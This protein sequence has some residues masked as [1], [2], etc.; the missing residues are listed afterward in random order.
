MVT[1]SELRQ[2]CKKEYWG[3]YNR[4]MH[5]VGFYLTKVF[6]N[7]PVTSNQITVVWLLMGIAGGIL[8]ATGI[9]KWMLLGIVIYHL[10]HFFDC[11]DGNLARYRNKSTVKGIYLEQISHHITI[12]IVLAGLSIGVFNMMQNWL[13]LYVGCILVFSFIFAKL[14]SSNLSY[15]KGESRD[16]VE[17]LIYGT[18]PRARG[19]LTSTFFSLIRVEHPLN[20]MFWLILFNLTHVALSLYA[21][22]FFA[23]MLRKLIVTLSTLQKIDDEK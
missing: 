14:F 13:W 2:R 21:F 23:E 5:E 10:G 9:Y 8:L 16:K 17:K 6:I 22:L 15:Y 19:K 1:V 20:L 7:T 4:A 11:V 3:F 18:N 12:I